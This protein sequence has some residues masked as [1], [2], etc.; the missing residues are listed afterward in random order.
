M[1]AIKNKVLLTGKIS[2][3]PEI[4][5]TK[6]GKKL[7]K[8]SIGITDFFSNNKGDKATEMQWHNLIAWGRVAE[9]AEKG[10]DKDIKIF[11]E[12]KLQRRN[13]TDKDGKKKYITEVIVQELTV[14]PQNV[15]HFE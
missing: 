14:I 1:E 8:F 4:I 5:T 9:Q 11:V 10:V 6:G 13:Y 7:A 12:G 15:D 2:R 3:K